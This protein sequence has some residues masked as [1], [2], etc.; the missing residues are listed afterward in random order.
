MLA[1]KLIVEPAIAQ[2][3]GLKQFAAD[4]RKIAGHDAV[5]YFGNLDYDFAFYNGRDLRLTS[6][7][8]PAAPAL[9]VSPED[10]WKLVAPR[11][12]DNYA[13]VLRS[14]PTDLDGSGACS[15]CA[16]ALARPRRPRLHLPRKRA[17]ESA[18][19]ASVVLRNSATAAVSR[20]RTSPV[21]PRTLK[22][23]IAVISDS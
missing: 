23:Q 13:V 8:D 18:P 15:C 6:P 1:I 20:G 19:H 16:I 22:S 4:A 7:A 14:N 21:G 11:W 2:T 17:P 3:L 5:G 12:S 10:D 9:I